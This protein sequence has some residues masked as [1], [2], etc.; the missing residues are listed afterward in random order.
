MRQHGT[1]TGWGTGWKKD[2]DDRIC[3]ALCGS[4]R[5]GKRTPSVALQLGSLLAALC[6]LLGGAARA[7]H[8]TAYTPQEQ[9]LLDA[10]QDGSLIRLH[11]LAA[12]DTP[13]AQRLKIQVRDAILAQF[14]ENW[15]DL[16]DDPD[17]IYTLLQQNV[18]AMKDVASAVT[19]GAGF[20]GRVTAQVGVMTLPPK[21][22]GQV[23][24]PRGQYRALRITL[25]EGQ[26][27]NWWC[28]LFPSL[29][30]AV[31]DDDPWRTPDPP[32]VG[33]E[34]AWETA[35]EPAISEQNSRDFSSPQLRWDGKALLSQWLCWPQGFGNQGGD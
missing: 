16:G 26:G 12:D 7:A 32:S 27:K 31:A 3:E 8:G 2:Y 11:I 28:V 20:A 10:Y 14:A 22:Y 19:T 1:W 25:G 34:D 30:L 18:D 13:A 6:L 15:A 24:L 9:A 5:R 35:V 23:L 17:A 29:C 33:G 21:R 4:Q